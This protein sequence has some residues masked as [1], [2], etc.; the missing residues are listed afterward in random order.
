MFVAIGDPFPGPKK[1]FAKVVA[2]AL[3]DMDC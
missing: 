2:V 3:Y 1:C